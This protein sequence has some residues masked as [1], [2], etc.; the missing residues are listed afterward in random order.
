MILV[1]GTHPLLDVFTSYGTQLFLPFTNTRYA[2]NGVAIIDLFYSGALVVA[3]FFGAL[4][5]KK[6]SVIG[7]VALTFTTAYLFVGMGINEQLIN[8]AKQELGMHNSEKI[9]AYPM[10]LQP[11]LRTILVK[12]DRETKVGFHSILDYNPIK[13]STQSVPNDPKSLGFLSTKEG[14]ILRW[15]TMDKVI[16]NVQDDKDDVKV[17]LASD[18]RYVTF[19]SP[20]VGLWGLRFNI[21][22]DKITGP[23]TYFSRRHTLN[24]LEVQSHL[25]QIWSRAFCIS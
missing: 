6:S 2:L 24:F 20:F 11:F 8:R 15:F 7:K 13:F 16:F 5:K 3:L 21:H 10:L 18:G 19:D 25:Q 4:F 23:A 14:K 9:S 22:D 12:G 17:I 1:I